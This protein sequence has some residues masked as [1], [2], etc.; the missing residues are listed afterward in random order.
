MA[1]IGLVK[2]ATV[3]LRIGQAVPPAYRSKFSTAWSW[4]E[5]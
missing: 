2:F 3:A 4:S 1:E 5:H